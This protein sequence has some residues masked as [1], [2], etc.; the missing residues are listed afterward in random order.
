MCLL[1]SQVRFPRLRPSIPQACF[2]PIPRVNR[3]GKA[4]RSARRCRGVRA[5][6]RRLYPVAPQHQV[7]Q[8]GSD[9]R[10]QAVGCA[11]AYLVEKA[12]EGGR[13]APSW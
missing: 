5:E 2:L 10:D 9:T 13:R 7:T 8:L 12:V 6:I 4:F 1:F 3:H 11:V